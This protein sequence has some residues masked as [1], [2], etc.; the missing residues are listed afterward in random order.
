MFARPSISCEPFPS[1]SSVQ[2]SLSLSSRPLL[3]PAKFATLGMFLTYLLLYESCS[4]GP[5]ILR[6]RTSRSQLRKHVFFSRIAGFLPCPLT[7]LRQ[8]M[9]MIIHIRSWGT[10]GICKC[11]PRPLP[12]HINTLILARARQHGRLACHVT[13]SIIIVY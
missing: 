8:Q 11:H 1:T 3:L 10:L 4:H 6:R 9:P 5:M 7:P 12:G 2:R 13:H